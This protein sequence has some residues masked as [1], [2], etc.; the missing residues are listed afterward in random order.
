MKRI[1]AFHR[2]VTKFVAPI[3][4]GLGAISVGCQ[5]SSQSANLRL[6]G[7]PVAS[8]SSAQ[9]MDQPG[10]RKPVGA[11]AT[12]ISPPPPQSTNVT[13]SYVGDEPIAQ[14]GFVDRLHQ[15]IACNAANGGQACG[16]CQTCV[17]TYDAA[18]LQR[19]GIDPQEWLCN[20][21]DQPPAAAL[22]ASDRVAGAEPQD[23]IVHYTTEAG[24]IKIA[25]SNPVC[26]YSPRFGA[27]RQVYSA[28]AG[29]KSIGLGKT[30][31]PV[32]P[33]G[34]G[35]S[36]P[37]LAINDVDELSHAN[38]SKR[39]DAMRDRNRGVPVENIVGPVFFEDV[40]QVLAALD[41][42]ALIQLN[43]SQIAILQRGAVAAQSWMIRDAVEVMIESMA[44]PT[45]I[46]DAAVE[47]FVE[48]DFPDAGRLQVV[49]VADRDHAVQGEE[50]NFAIH[51]RN[52]GDSP[53][54]HIELVDNLVARLEY[55]ADSQK[56]D[57]PAEFSK[58][59]NDVGSE[60]LTWTLRDAL[61]VGET[62]TIEFTCKVR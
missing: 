45:L 38:V 6:P 47:G 59:L 21:G 46:R 61:P 53:V 48:Y 24:D 18:M 23:A 37:S 30:Y 7:T 11:L 1:S 9:A 4:I 28:V 19:R 49:K 5:T 26:L 20:G 16:S 17:P 50:V 27:V 34:V 52:V 29:E 62:I 44:P 57:R 10:G 8:D 40:W 41:R 13:S 43:E 60:T 35:L 51:L 31:L 54:D 14:V 42:Q 55:V 33:G 32:G 12:A 39:V 58:A 25:A 2:C 15:R 22:L 3:A 36:Q 56:S